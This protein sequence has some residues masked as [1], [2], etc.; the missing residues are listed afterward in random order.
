MVQQEEFIQAVNSEL[1]TTQRKKD[2]CEK[3]LAK[4]NVDDRQMNERNAQLNEEIRQLQQ[5]Q[6]DEQKKF[7]AGKKEYRQAMEKVTDN[8]RLVKKL[9]AKISKVQNTITTLEENIQAELNSWVSVYLDQIQFQI[10][11]IDVAILQQ[12]KPNWRDEAR[13]WREIGRTWSEAC[14][15]WIHI[16]EP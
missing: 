13:K 16:E 14:W 11:T 6:S 2:E 5:T 12:Q 15:L 8:E 9:E 10:S 7:D 4:Y 3:Q 1:E